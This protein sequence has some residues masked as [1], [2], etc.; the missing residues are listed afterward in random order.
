MV[1]PEAILPCPPEW[2]NWLRESFIVPHCLIPHGNNDLFSDGAQNVSMK[3]F[4]P[5]SGTSIRE[6][7]GRSSVDLMIQIRFSEMIRVGLLPTIF[8]VLGTITHASI[9]S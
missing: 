1:S 8:F 4:G 3:V 2:V 9:G 5:E 7:L 6:H